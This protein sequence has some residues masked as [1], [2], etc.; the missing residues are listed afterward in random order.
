MNP[1]YRQSMARHPQ[2]HSRHTLSSNPTAPFPATGDWT[3]HRRYDRPAEQPLEKRELRQSDDAS[4]AAATRRLLE[5]ADVRMDGARPW[6]LRIRDP[7]FHRRVLTGGSLGLGEAYMDGW[8]DCQRLDAFF[9]RILRAGL[10]V[11]VIPLRDRLRLIG[12]RLTNPG[13]RAMAFDI[14]R[15]HYDLGNR[16]YGAML[17]RR[18]IYSCAYWPAADDLDAAQEA[19][20]DLICRKLDLKPGM[21]LLDVGCGWGGLMRHAVRRHGVS[22]VGITVSTEQA[23]EARRRCA[24]LPVEI[25]LQ[26]YRDIQGTFER[27]VS[28]GMMEHVGVKNYPVF[29]ATVRRHLAEDGLFLLHTIGNNRSQ[30]NTDPWIARY[31]FPNSML[32]SARQLCRAAEPHFVMEDWHNFGADYDRTLMAW[33]ANFESRWEDLRSALRRALPPHV[34]LLP[35]LLRRGFSGPPDPGLANRL[36]AAWGAGRLRGAAVVAED[37]GRGLVSRGGAEDAEEEVS[38]EAAKAQRGK[39]EVVG[40]VFNR[41]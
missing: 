27:I 13:R 21:R 30:C 14:G 41:D 33:A 23:G 40:A 20:L 7:R 28:V 25:R 12:A 39:R 34:A 29:Y 24:G 17:D 38:R 1:L 16:L 26:D 2:P 3:A 11:R 6:D 9:E 37:S 31:I 5:S 36:F 32:P 18:M 4:W 15:H 8:W 22:A 10:D 35:P 19:K